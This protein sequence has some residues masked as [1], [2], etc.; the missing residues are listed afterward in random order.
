MSVKENKALVLRV[1]DEA[2]NQKSIDAFDEFV[3]EDA[4][5]HEEMPGLPTR[6]PA[7]P[8]AAFTMFFAAFPDL[9][10]EVDEVIAEGDKVA[11]R[12]TMTG[13]HEGEFMGIPPTNKSFAV[14]VID[15]FEVGGGQI[16]AH[17]GTTD[18]AAMMEQLGLAPDM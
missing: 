12:C 5:E 3:S 10:M 7:A 8:K 16:T 6:G 1:Y 15:M 13:T 18:Q 4:V 2:I 17:W 11:V 9:A 14:Q